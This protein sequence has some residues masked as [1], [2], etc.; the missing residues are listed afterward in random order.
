MKPL[1]R[2]TSC[3]DRQQS[4]GPRLYRVHPHQMECLT[5]AVSVRHGFSASIEAPHGRPTNAN[6]SAALVVE[7]SHKS[8]STLSKRSATQT[9]TLNR[10]S[11]V[12]A[13]SPVTFTS[14]D[15]Q[16]VAVS[17]DGQAQAVFR[18]VPAKEGKEAR[19]FVEIVGLQ[20][21]NLV[22]EIEVTKEH[23]D[24]YFDSERRQLH[25]LFSQSLTPN[26][27]T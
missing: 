1:L 23:G 20:H 16:H 27:A 13:S 14:A 22:E 21:G 25:M 26:L 24:W 2:I 17:P 4:Q 6:L 3:T 10:E 11:N 18:S 15:V 9:L 12:M 7:T 19:K 5:T 8:I